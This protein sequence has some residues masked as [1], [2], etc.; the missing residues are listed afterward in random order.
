MKVGTLGWRV[1]AAVTPVVALWPGVLLGALLALEVWSRRRTPS[2]VRMWVAVVLAVIALADGAWIPVWLAENWFG[3]LVSQV[4]AGPLLLYVSHR[5]SRNE[6]PAAGAPVSGMAATAETARLVGRAGGRVK[7]PLAEDSPTREMVVDE[8]RGAERGPEPE[9]APTSEPARG[10]EHGAEREPV[11]EPVPPQGGKV[12]RLPS[13]VR[14]GRSGGRLMAVELPGGL[15]RHVSVLGDSGTGKTTTLIRLIHDALRAG[16][17][18]FCAD[19]K[20]T[21]TLRDATEDLAG[22][23]ELPYRLIDPTERE[24]LKYNIARGEP[25]EVSNKLL[26]AFRFGPS[27]EIFKQVSQEVIPTLVQALREAGEPVTLKTLA[28]YLDPKAL[29]GFARAGGED[30]RE[31]AEMVG[32]GKVY[33]ESIAGM[34]AR[35]GALRRG[36]F[37]PVFDVEDEDEGLDVYEALGSG[38][39]YVSMPAMASSE[40]TE[41]MARVLMQ[42]LKQAAAERLRE[43]RASGGEARPA[44]L[45]MDEFASFR[46]AEQIEDLLGQAREA[47]VAAVLSTLRLPGSPDLRKAMLSAGLLIS[48]ATNNTDAGEVARA[49]GNRN[50]LD[51]SRSRRTEEDGEGSESIST[52]KVDKFTVEPDRIGKFSVGEAAVRLRY[53]NTRKVAVVQIE[54][55]KEVSA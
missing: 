32:R 4:L 46:E 43:R 52:R 30:A 2:R 49:M 3:V 15:A 11:R 33:E 9:P 35:F 38:V 6:I 12:E 24:T 7:H 36:T 41:L 42:D 39:T 37:G 1:A 23:F 34:R 55:V 10:V 27:A 17:A 16:Y 44:L 45:V 19:A 13:V 50:A 47:G 21:G 18:V 29:K 8:G 31:L 5:I 20:G 22:R 40:D 48:H 26:G 25:A 53:G 28:T 51:V 14:L 54:P